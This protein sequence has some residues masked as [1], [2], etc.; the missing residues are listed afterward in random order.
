MV[1][2]VRAVDEGRWRREKVPAAEVLCG[3]ENRRQCQSDRNEKKRNTSACVAVEEK[4]R[5]LKEE[6]YGGR[7]GKDRSDGETTSCRL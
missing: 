1:Y 6:L 5:N 7:L 4:E 2:D 3:E